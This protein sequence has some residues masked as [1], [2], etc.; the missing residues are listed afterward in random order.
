[1]ENIYFDTESSEMTEGVGGFGGAPTTPDITAKT[2]AEM[3][4][5]EMVD[6]LNANATDGP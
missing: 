2:T 3:K 1:M 5:N 4:T 6:F